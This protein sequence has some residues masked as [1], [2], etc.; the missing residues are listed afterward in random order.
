[1]KPLKAS[2]SLRK[3]QTRVITYD[4]I[5]IKIANISFEILV[6]PYIQ[7]YTWSCDKRRFAAYDDI[8][9]RKI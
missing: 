4:P 6:F 3:W 9:R 7:W 8:G 5:Y 1:M 2:F